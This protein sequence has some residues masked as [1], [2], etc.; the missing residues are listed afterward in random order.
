MKKLVY[1][2]LIAAITLSVSSF[3]PNEDLDLKV[4][5]I[6]QKDDKSTTMVDESLVDMIEFS[7]DCTD[8][9]KIY[10]FLEGKYAGAIDVV[11]RNKTSLM[12]KPGKYKYTAKSEKGE[13]T[14]E[15]E[16]VCPE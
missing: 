16:I 15:G 3:K 12:K 10:I 8:C 1:I 9:G 2:V 6:K 7:C 14:A 5:A 11:F 13:K 4:T